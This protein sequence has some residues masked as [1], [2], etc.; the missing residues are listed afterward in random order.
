[1]QIDDNIQRDD[2]GLVRCRHCSTLLGEPGV[3]PLQHAIRREQ[4]AMAAGPGVHADPARFTNR[5]IV[6]RQ[7]FCPG[8]LALLSTEIVPAD[9]PSSRKWCIAPQE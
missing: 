3:D 1:M 5:P 6:L 7:A 4:P 2:D 9:E 8:C